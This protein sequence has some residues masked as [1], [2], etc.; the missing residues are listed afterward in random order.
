MP[1]SLDGSGSISGIS[2]F[3]FSDE[4]IHTG[5]TNTA[6]KFPAN[7]TITFETGG[8]ERLR[9]DSNGIRTPDDIFI[10]VRGKGFKTS[11]WIITNTTS[12]NALSFS[13]GASSGEK[14]RIDGGGGLQLGTSTAT[15]S[16]L[17]VYGAN[18]AAAIFQGSNTGTGAGNGFI[19]GNN[20]DVN[21]FV[22]NYENGFMHFGTNNVERLR[23]A[24]DG[25]VGIGTNN[26]TTNLQV[27]HATNE[28]TFSLFNGGT[29]KAALQTQNSFGTILYSYDNEPLK[30]SV[31]SGTSYSEKLRIT[32]SDIITNTSVG[33]VLL[34]TD[35]ARTFNSHNGRLQVTGTTYSH[36]TISVISNTNANNGAYLFLGKQRSGAVGGS[37]AVQAGDLIGEIRFPAADGTDM[38]NYA[39]RIIVSADQ[40]ASSNNTS[41]IMDFHTTRR[42]GS[43]HLKLR[44]G[45]NS[46]QG[47]QFSFGTETSDLNNTNTGDR[48][49]LKVGPT[50]H[51]EGVF[52]HNG[53]PGMYYNCYSGGNE[54][55]YRGT[56]QPNGGDYRPAAYGQKYGGHYFYSDNSTTQWNAQQQIT[57]MQTNMQITSQGYVKKQYQPA[58][59]AVRSSGTVGDSANQKIVF[60]QALTN[61]GNHYNTS[62]GY[63]TAPIAGTYFFSFFGMNNNAL[64]WYNFRKNNS[65]ISPQH[66]A[67][68]TN[69][70]DWS[71]VGMTIVIVLA[72]ND[73]MAIYT[74]N[75][76]RIGM[77]GQGNNHNGFCGYMLG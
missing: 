46:N 29:K 42:N 31:A 60:N 12:G 41:G 49:S 13:G 44:I 54:N 14:L 8:S 30:F 51:I 37:T 27:N 64:A 18:D 2:T 36:S 65:V 11:D 50:T 23:I 20:G 26:P 61:V 71:H 17:T 28:C 34:G 62:N 67:Y 3:S 33:H 35:T 7:D 15:A 75:D 70:S 53:T 72:A 39:A 66:G 6:I 25:K 69:G 74:G 43:P 22:W 21:A 47:T 40:N 16:K 57:S 68:M 58:F 48:T 76:P 59:D 24:S 56:R 5:D 9:L 19:T 55:F 32:T 38:E 63:F 52:G 4:I 1:I 77:Y 73:T 10:N 45:Q